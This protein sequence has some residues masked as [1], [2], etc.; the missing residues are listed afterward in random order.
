[1]KR[2]PGSAVAVSARHRRRH[3]QGQAR[4]VRHG[5]DRLPLQCRQ[6]GHSGCHGRRGGTQGE[7][8]GRRHQLQP[9][10]HDEVRY[11]SERHPDLP[12]VACSTTAFTARSRASFGA[13]G[14]R[15]SAT[16]ITSRSRFLSAFQISGCAARRG[17]APAD[18]EKRTAPARA[19]RRRPD[20]AARP[21][22]SRLR[23][24]QPCAPRR[25]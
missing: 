21:T 1:M 4:P 8:H 11:L 3:H 22:T 24:L 17:R 7:K 9:R 15:S 18:L 5:H 2:V 16:P 12:Q 14:C 10:S 25:Q 19:W 20:G 6:P 13:L 23:A